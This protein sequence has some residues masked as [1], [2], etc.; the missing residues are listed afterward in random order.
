MGKPQIIETASGE[1]LAVLP[2]VEYERMVEALEE[3]ADIQAYDEAMA[4][5]EEYFPAEVIDRIVDGENPI[6]VYR[7][8]RGL[9]LD[10]LAQQCGLSK[11]YLSQLENGKRSGVEAK[12]KKIAPALGVEPDM[13]LV[14]E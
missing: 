14:S 10:Q 13:L 6:R 5:D 11:P 3:K 7:E 8:Y 1:K 4:R 9:T 2:L 12:L